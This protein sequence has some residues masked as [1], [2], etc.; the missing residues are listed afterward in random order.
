M[1]LQATALAMLLAFPAPAFSRTE[2]Y[3]SRCA[4]MADTIMI[5]RQA[6]VATIAC[7]QA[8]H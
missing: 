2:A 6:G 5:Q 7:L 3:C 8:L 1:K 4:R